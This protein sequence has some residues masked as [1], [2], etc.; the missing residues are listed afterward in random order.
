MIHFEDGKKINFY[1]A[2]SFWS[3]GKRERGREKGEKGERG[4]RGGERGGG[5]R[6]REEGER[7][8]EIVCLVEGDMLP[9]G[10][11]GGCCVWSVTA[12]GLVQVF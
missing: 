2:N 9:W 7:E 4:E 8:E 12:S 3:P 11:L 1:W 10:E 5:E 6:E